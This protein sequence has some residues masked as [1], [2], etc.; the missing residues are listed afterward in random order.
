MYIL[1]GTPEDIGRG[2]VSHT[3]DEET[4]IIGRD[5]KNDKVSKAETQR[6]LEQQIDTMEKGKTRDVYDKIWHGVK[7][8]M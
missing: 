1:K 6:M 5:T 4:V 7:Q 2:K 8:D 3:V